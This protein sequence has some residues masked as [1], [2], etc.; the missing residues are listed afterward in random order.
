MLVM[1][2]L[3]GPTAVA[4][5]PVN[6]ERGSGLGISYCLEP[7]RAVLGIGQIGARHWPHSLLGVWSTSV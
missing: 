5:E 6:A 3:A 2:Y 7:E 1:G 4:L